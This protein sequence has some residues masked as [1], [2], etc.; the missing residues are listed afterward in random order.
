[1]PTNIST[2]SEAEIFIKGTFASPAIAF[3]NNVFP[4][5]GGPTN[6]TPFGIVAPT[7]LKRFDSFI[8]LTISS[9]SSFTSSIPAISL[10]LTPVFTLIF[11]SAFV[12]LKFGN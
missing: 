4:V 6:K 10:K 7:A 12:S 9:N 11:I 3:A 5:P 1:M 8:K 2:N